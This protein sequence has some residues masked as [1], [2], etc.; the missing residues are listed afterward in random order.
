MGAVSLFRAWMYGIGF[1][2]ATTASLA[3]AFAVAITGPPTASELEDVG[4]FFEQVSREA[5][6][7][8]E[9]AGI[10]LCVQLPREVT[11]SLC[12]GPT[13]V[14]QPQRVETATA[15]APVD[16][17]S[18]RDAAPEPTR[19]FAR[20][21]ESLLGSEAGDEP[22]RVDRTVASAEP[23]ERARVR[24]RA[25][26][27]RRASAERRVRPA[28]ARVDRR[29]ARP[30]IVGPRNEPAE[31]LAEAEED[32]LAELAPMTAQEIAAERYEEPTQN[33]AEP[34]DTFPEENYDTEYDEQLAYEEERAQE[35]EERY[36]A[37]REAREERRRYRRWLR[38]QAYYE[39]GRSGGW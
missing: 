15:D 8:I 5:A 30:P 7:V 21:G 1:F 17:P 16:Q 26:P 37:W 4:A 18:A 23:V 6:P 12:P 14:E 3:I 39:Q 9:A 19:E 22:V 33:Q 25:R 10:E 20:G 27:D 34:A 2:I 28:S 24:P 31:R 32:A 11:G 13:Q 29:S 36:R 38:R 35:E